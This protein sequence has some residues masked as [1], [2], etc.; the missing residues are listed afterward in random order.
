MKKNLLLL[1]AVATFGFANAQIKE[2]GTFELTPK[3]GASSF[4]EVTNKS[5]NGNNIN[6][7][8]SSS[9]KTN[10]GVSFSL[11]GD[12]YFNNRWSIRGGISFDKMGGTFTVQGVSF[13]DRFRYITIPI[14]ANWHFG[15]T[16]K[17]NL[18]FGLSPSFLSSAYGIVN[19]NETK[20][21]ET[22]ISTSQIGLS[23]GIGYKIEIN[24]NFGILIDYQ[25]F[26]GLTNISKISGFEVKNSGGSFNIGGV[27][28]L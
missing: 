23:L 18:N 1:V 8:N 19:S 10:S 28:Q 2:K 4:A 13:E 5:T 15:S 25:S 3:I 17:W 14:N 24:P 11:T 16:R 26:S 21:E 27:I 22:Q 7:S 9:T 6:T 20:I 12:Y